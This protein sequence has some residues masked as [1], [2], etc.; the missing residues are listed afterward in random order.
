MGEVHHLS[1]FLRH[2]QLN[3]TTPKVNHSHLTSMIIWLLLLS[4]LTPLTSNDPGVRGLLA[5]SVTEV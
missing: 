2:L 1:S 4:D 3:E 5:L